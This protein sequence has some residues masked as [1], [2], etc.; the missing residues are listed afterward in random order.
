MKAGS[1]GRLRAVSATFVPIAGATLG[2]RRGGQLPIPTEAKFQ[3]QPVM[4]AQGGFA[5]LRIAAR[6]FSSFFNGGTRE[7]RI[8]NTVNS[9]GRDRRGHLLDH[10]LGD[11]A[12]DLA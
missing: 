3:H 6:D 7:V 8:S 1:P 11:I 4:T 12:A 5:P 10:D 9:T 2:A